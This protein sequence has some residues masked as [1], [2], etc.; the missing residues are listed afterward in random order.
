M[1][2]QAGDR[3]ECG[4]CGATLVYEKQ[5]P[6]CSDESHSEMCCDKPMSKVSV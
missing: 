5:C 3:Y 2:R 4:V 1:F 6:C